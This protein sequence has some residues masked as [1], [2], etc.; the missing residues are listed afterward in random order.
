MSEDTIAYNHYLPNEEETAKPP[1]IERPKNQ[2]EEDTFH[3]ALATM[4]KCKPS[5]ITITIDGYWKIY[6]INGKQIFKD[7]A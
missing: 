6:S 5:D 2:E 3:K 1:V 4:H 7:R